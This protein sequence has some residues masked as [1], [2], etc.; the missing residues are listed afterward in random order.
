M[1]KTI[2]ELKFDPSQIGQ[3]TNEAVGG[4]PPFPGGE[5]KRT[6]HMVPVN[7]LAEQVRNRLK[8]IEESIERVQRAQQDAEN[9]RAAME[10]QFTEVVSSLVNETQSRIEKNKTE[11][12][13]SAAVIIDRLLSEVHA[14]TAS[15]QEQ[16]HHIRD[17]VSLLSVRVDAAAPR[18]TIESSLTEIRNAQRTET[19]RLLAQIESIQESIQQRETDK[20]NAQEQM[21]I[22]EAVEFLN[23]MRKDREQMGSLA[24]SMI[25]QQI[26]PSNATKK[27]RS[28]KKVTQSDN[29][30]ETLS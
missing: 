15:L 16:I 19:Q 29:A 21:S 23:Q 27:R 28:R 10:K 2:N 5:K 9:S 6:G 11:S 14:V 22:D 12:Q 13:V 17:R 7:S 26:Q 20:N 3:M 18:E 30:D 25:A 8:S 4:P 1:G 24:E